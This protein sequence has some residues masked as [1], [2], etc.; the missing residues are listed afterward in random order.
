MASP[1]TPTKTL[2]SPLLP[3]QHIPCP[4]TPYAL[5]RDALLIK[6]VRPWTPM[7]FPVGPI[8]LVVCASKYPIVSE[9]LE[10]AEAENLF[11]G[12][13][14]PTPTLPSPLTAKNGVDVPVSDTTNS[15]RLSPPKFPSGCSMDTIP[16]GV[17]VPKPSLPA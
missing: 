15:G 4:N 16:Q 11:P 13:V 7:K 12:V 2:V 3:P 9:L 17:V 1:R 10:A 5:A 14:V 6:E 8:V